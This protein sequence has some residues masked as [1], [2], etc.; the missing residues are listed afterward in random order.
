MIDHSSFLWLNTVFKPKSV[1]RLDISRLEARNQLRARFY[2]ISLAWQEART[3]CLEVWTPYLYLSA[4]PEI[5]AYFKILQSS[6]LY[7][8]KGTLWQ[9][10]YK[11][12]GQKNNHFSILFIYNYYRFNFRMLCH[13]IFYSELVVLYLNWA[14]N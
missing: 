13:I 7:L 14:T 5:V 1:N 2:T 4:P 6:D 12:F 3:L 9:I 8:V 10:Y 11:F